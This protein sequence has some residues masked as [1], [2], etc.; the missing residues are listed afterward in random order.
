MLDLLFLDHPIGLS[1]SHTQRIRNNY[2]YL[3]E[4]LSAGGGFVDQLFEAG[5]LD[6]Y[7]ISKVQSES[8]DYRRFEVLLDIMMRK[9]REQ[10]DRFLQILQDTGQEHIASRLAASLDVTNTRSK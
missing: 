3:M 6:Y 1:M 8:M 2:M 4:T 9:P 10:F 5:I 7:D